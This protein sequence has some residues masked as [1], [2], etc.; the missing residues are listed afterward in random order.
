MYLISVYFDEKTNLILQRYINKIAAKTGNT[1]MTDNH[2]PPHMT[3][4]AIEARSVQILKPVFIGL[5]GKIRQGKIKFV[6]VGQL[7]PYVMYVTPVL[8]EYLLDVSKQVYEAV[9]DIPETAVSR[10]YQPLSWLPHVT[11]GKKLDKEQMIKA[12]GVLQEGFAP[13]D[14]TVTQIGLA[15]VN[16][17]EDVERF[18]L[19]DA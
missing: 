5:Q 3:I 7:L 1:F 4:S 19:V 12:L 10:Y 11:V 2:V 18:E 17:H 13:F 9:K 8:N 14:A 6:S 15:K 16:P